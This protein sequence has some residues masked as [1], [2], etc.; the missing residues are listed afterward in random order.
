MPTSDFGKEWILRV[1][2]LCSDTLATSYG[3]P[4]SDWAILADWKISLLV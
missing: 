3:F 2:E 4:L 1:F